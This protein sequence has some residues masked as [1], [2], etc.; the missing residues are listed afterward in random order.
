[1]KVASWPSP[2]EEGHCPRVTGS[3]SKNL[4]LAIRCSAV[5]RIDPGTSHSRFLCLTDLRPM[6]RRQ[7]RPRILTLRWCA[8]GVGEGLEMDED[9]AQLQ[10]QG[11][12][13]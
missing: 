13:Y 10:V 5:K 1:M 12:T 4:T 7:S 11:E 6:G 2:A 9:D 3:V 8:C